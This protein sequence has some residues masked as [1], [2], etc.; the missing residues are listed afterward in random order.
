MGNQNNYHAAGFD[1]AVGVTANPVANINVTGLDLTGSGGPF[2]EGHVFGVR[3]SAGNT[4][5][6]TLKHESASSS[7]AN[8][9]FFSDAADMTITDGATIF[10]IYHLG[11]QRW[12]LW[13]VKG[14]AGAAGAAG[15]T[16]ATG[17]AVWLPDPPADDDPFVW[18]AAAAGAAA[19][20]AGSAL[21]VRVVTSPSTI[22]LGDQT[23][24]LYI[25]ASS[26]GTI[27]WAAIS[28][29]AAT[30]GAKA[31]FKKNGTDMWAGSTKPEV[32]GGGGV[33][34]ERTPDS[35][36]FHLAAADILTLN[37]TV[38]TVG[39]VNVMYGFTPD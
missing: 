36:S 24:D 27:T 18:P 19:A 38:S 3:L 17:P 32:P 33:S 15:A 31:T 26:D 4:F 12:T 25:T 11:K 13:G 9:F 10:L 35:G 5:S 2:T 22:S 34:A 16:G 20:A 29:A 23:P 6:L 1:V 37:L 21:Q 28:G 7:A 8:R 39:P 14:S 30:A